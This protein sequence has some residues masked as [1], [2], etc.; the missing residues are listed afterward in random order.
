MQK[1]EYRSP[2]F[3]V[4]FP[5]QFAVQNLMLAGRCTEISVEGMRLEFQEPLPPNS[6]GT[7][8]MNY[9]GNTVEL[10]V[11]IAYAGEMH[12]GLEFIYE[13]DQERSE[14]ADLVASLAVLQS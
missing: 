5:V 12:T 2:R 9:Q 14:V 3:P 1:F 7:V 11:R 4:D 10:K 8:F 13:S 6:R